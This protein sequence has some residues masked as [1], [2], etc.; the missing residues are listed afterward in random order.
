MPAKAN[1][2]DETREWLDH[3]AET[4]V[5]TYKKAMLAPVI[6]AVV[7]CHQ[8]LGVAEIAERAMA[9]TGWTLTERGMYRTVKRLEGQEFLS[10]RHVATARTG[11][12]SKEISLTSLGAEYL[13][14]VR[15]STVTLPR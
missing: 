13:A 3:Q 10:S 15:A 6:L 4:W 14:R 9:A 2:P 8:P 7:E 11:A 12:K 1:R 5:G